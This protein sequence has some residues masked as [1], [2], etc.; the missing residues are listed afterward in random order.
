MNSPGESKPIK[1]KHT[2]LT[3]AKKLDIIRDVEAREISYEQ[4]AKKYGVGCSSVSRFV[5]QKETIKSKVDT[6]REHGV[7]ERRTLKVQ[8]FPLLEQALFVWVLQQRN[9]NVVVPSEVLK[10]KA[11]QLFEHFQG[12]GCYEECHFLASNGWARRFRNRFGLRTA[13]EKAAAGRKL[14]R[15]RYTFMPCSN[16]DGTLKL[17]LMFIGM[18]E[19]PRDLPRDK[20]SLPVSYYNAKKAWMTRALFQKW[21]DEEFVPAVRKFSKEN[22]LEPKAL[23]VLDNCSAHHIG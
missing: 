15:I 6:Y 13:D 11:K 17:K 23:L 1:R 18:S 22:D 3:L 7:E 14:N 5:K 2:T 10:A 21:F 8:S 12:K 19:N 16:M 4:I 20:K 9:A